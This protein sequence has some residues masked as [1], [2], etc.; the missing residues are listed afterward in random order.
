[1]PAFSRACLARKLAIV[2]VG[3][4]ATPLLKSRVRFCI[5]AAH[6]RRD[7]DDALRILDD[8]GDQVFFATGNFATRAADDR[9]WWQVMVKYK[10][11]STRSWFS[12]STTTNSD[13]TLDEPPKA[14]TPAANKTRNRAKGCHK[15]TF[16]K[17]RKLKKKGIRYVPVYDT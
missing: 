6:D 9:A 16:T 11:P 10:S 17:T 13:R 4:P 1:M 3:S 12:W 15:A 7:L 8:I 2:V 5:S 14:S